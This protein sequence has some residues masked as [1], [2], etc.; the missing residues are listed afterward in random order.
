[1]AKTRGGSALHPRPLS[2]VQ[3]WRGPSTHVT[4]AYPIICAKS[5]YRAPATSQTLSHML[6]K[7]QQSRQSPHPFEAYILMWPQTSC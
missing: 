6:G 4:H 2:H 3:I 7:E 5:I 1:M